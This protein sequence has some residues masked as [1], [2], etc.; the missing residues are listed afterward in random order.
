MSDNMIEVH[1]F[2][3]VRERLGL[4]SEQIE[5][6]P[7]I[8]TVSSL[9]DALVQQHGEK[10][11]KVLREGRILCAVNQVVAELQSP[12]AAGDEVAFFG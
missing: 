11:H 8:S 3:S 7:A 4:E 2:A 12:L 9:I 5:V 1:Y 6:V 10:W